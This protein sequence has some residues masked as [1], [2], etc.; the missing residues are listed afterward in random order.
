[1]LRIQREGEA[2]PLTLVWNSQTRFIEGTRSVTAA[3]VT[4]GTAVTVSYHTPFFGKR[5][6]TKIV[7][8]RGAVSPKQH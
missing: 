5:F 4:K 6:A 3:E 1:M 2:V 7:I 8:E